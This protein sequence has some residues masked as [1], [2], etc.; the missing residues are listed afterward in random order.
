M[1]IFALECGKKNVF[2]SLSRIIGGREVY[3]NEY[4]WMASI[5]SVN[6]SQVICGGS[7]INDRY[8]V[9]AAHCIV[10]G[11]IYTLYNN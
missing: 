1:I 3:E 8:V 10:Y 5:I 9:T 2:L 11:Y 4:P 6:R 7:V